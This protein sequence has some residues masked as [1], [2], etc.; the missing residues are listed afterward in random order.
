MKTTPRTTIMSPEIGRALSQGTPVVALESTVITHGLPEPENLELALAMETEVREQGALPATI[1]VLDGR[2]HIGLNQIQLTRLAAREGVRKISV[3][4]LGVALARKESGGTTVS[5]TLFVARQAGIKVLATG[6]IGGAHH[7]PAHDV[8][9][10]LEQLARTPL[11]VVCAG[12]K[13]V[14]DLPATLERLES[15]AVPVAGYRTDTLPAF[16]SRSSGLGLTLRVDGA[17]E[18]AEIARAH[19]GLGLM[20]ALLV[21]VPPPEEVAME[22]AAVQEAVKRALAEAE[23]GGRVGPEVTPFLLQ[24]VSELTGG[25]SLRA[26]L[27]LLRHNAR[28]GAQIAHELADP[29]SRSV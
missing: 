15:L 12:P 6:G 9:A 3:R 11:A 24:R 13:A 17:Q 7:A 5:G 1:G 18:A 4:D 27:G 22:P 21:V 2:I 16:Y 8:S 10:D 25:A 28:I 26:N 23:A 29:Q 20:S 14:L 19:W